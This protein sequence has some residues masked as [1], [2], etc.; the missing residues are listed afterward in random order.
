MKWFWQT[1]AAWGERLLAIWLI[2]TGILALTGVG[3]TIP[4]VSL[5]MALLA[6]AAGVLLLLKR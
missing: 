4:H 1:R 6:V 3:A 5:I 2:A